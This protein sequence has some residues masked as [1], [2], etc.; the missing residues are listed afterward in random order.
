MNELTEILAKEIKPAYGCSGPIGVAFAA[1]EAYC[2][3]GGDIKKIQALID[4]DM[5]TKNSDVGI[6]PSGIRGIKNSLIVGALCGTQ[7]KGLAVLEEATAAS[8]EMALLKS[9]NI[10]IDIKPDWEC[11]QIGVY[12]D[13]SIETDKGTGRAIVAKTHSNL[14]YL[15]ANGKKYIDKGYDRYSILDEA[16]DPIRKYMLSDIYNYVNSTPAAQ[17][18]FLKEA[19]KMN[20]DLA[21]Y[22]INE[23]NKECIFGKSVIKKA[24]DDYVKKAK[25]MTAAAAEARMNGEAMPAMS[26]ATSGNAGIC[27]TVPLYCIAH[28][29][30]IE[31]EILLRSL[32][33]AYLVTIKIKNCIGRHSAMCACVCGAAPGVSAG[34]AYMLGG[35]SITVE[36][37]INNTIVNI[38]GV[39]CDGARRACALKLS[40]A[41]A[42]AI[43]AANMALD[44]I[45]TASDEGVIAKNADESIK[46][47][48]EFARNGMK[49]T[50]LMM[51]RAL[52]DKHFY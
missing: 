9:D 6:P 24:G 5:C 38:F 18:C 33:L 4:K 49:T 44:G 20:M 51:C 42:M 16:D 25:A 22:G 10:I 11:D 17:I 27:C 31:E 52:F 7:G 39:L 13:V 2:V 29:K 34:V 3:I 45:T 48:G 12:I 36:M 35:D 21:N 26:C 37:A 41:A 23:E 1:C 46:F 32:A 15:E 50:D 19:V 40:S 43:D 47:L 28:E 14:V 30:E 8:I